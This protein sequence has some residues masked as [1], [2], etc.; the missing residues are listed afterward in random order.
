MQTKSRPNP[1]AARPR[2]DGLS[3]IRPMS[4]LPMKCRPHPTSAQQQANN[5]GLMSF[6]RHQANVVLTFGLCTCIDIQLILYWQL[7]NVFSTHTKNMSKCSNHI[8]LLRNRTTLHITM[9]MSSVHNQPLQKFGPLR[10]TLQS[11]YMD[12]L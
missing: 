8:Y 9:H 6:Y 4:G 10:A 2:A 1:T 11:N 7:A 5:I 3:G 12:E